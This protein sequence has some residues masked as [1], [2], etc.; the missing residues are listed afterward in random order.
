MAHKQL[1]KSIDYREIG[2]KFG[3]GSSTACKKVNTAGT[4]ENLFRQVPVLAHG[5]QV[6]PLQ[7]V[8]EH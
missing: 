7:P 4:D 6:L 8:P 1:E 3:V 5:A 2:D